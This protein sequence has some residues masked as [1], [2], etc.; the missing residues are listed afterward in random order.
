MQL[1]LFTTF[2]WGVWSFSGVFI[3][4]YSIYLKDELLIITSSINVSLSAMIL[5]LKSWQL[6]VDNCIIRQIEDYDT[7]FDYEPGYD[8]TISKPFS[9]RGIRDL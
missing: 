8:Y 1:Y 9:C 3:L 4:G 7:E 6:S 5:A 2:I